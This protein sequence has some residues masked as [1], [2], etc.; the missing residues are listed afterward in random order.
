MWQIRCGVVSSRLQSCL[1]ESAFASR[2]LINSWRGCCEISCRTK[3]RL[4]WRALSNRATMTPNRI[5]AHR[6][7]VCIIMTSHNTPQFGAISR[8]EFTRWRAQRAGICMLCVRG[9]CAREQ[10]V[11]PPPDTPP[12]PT[13]SSFR[14]C[15]RS[16]ERELILK[17]R[18]L[19]CESGARIEIMLNRYRDD[20]L[21]ANLDLVFFCHGLK[22]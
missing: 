4:S 16:P 13:R 14:L 15:S 2:N 8:C 17:M 9:V 7:P 1:L 20:A 22:R 3:Q 12:T 18:R 21:F 19:D 6:L 10:R 11:R 5:L